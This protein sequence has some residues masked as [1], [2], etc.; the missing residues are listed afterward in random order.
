MGVQQFVSGVAKLAADLWGGS[1]PTVGSNI[2]RVSATQRQSDY[3]IALALYEGQH[4]YFLREDIDQQYSNHFTRK[5]RKSS[6]FYFN[7]LRK[8]IDARARVYKSM[9]KFTG[10]SPQV[11]ELLS[12]GSFWGEIIQADR[13]SELCDLCPVLIL[14]TR[15]NRLSFECVPPDQARIDWDPYVRN[16]VRRFVSVTEAA[17]SEEGKTSVYRDVWTSDSHRIY[18]DDTD[19]T[20]EVAEAQGLA[21]TGGVN[22]WG[23]VPI[24]V[25]RARVAG[26]NNPWGQMRQD[27]IRSQRQLNVKLTDLNYLIKLYYSQVVIEG[28]PKKLGDFQVGADRP[29]ILKQELEGKSPTAKYLT[30]EVEIGSVWDAIKQ[31]IQYIAFNEGLAALWDQ[32]G[33]ASTSGE[34]RKVANADMQ[35]IRESK[36]PAHLR[37]WQDVERVAHVVLGLG[38]PD[39]ADRIKIEFGDVGVYMD[40][41]EQRAAWLEEIKAGISTRAQWYMEAHPGTSEEEAQEKVR[42][43]LAAERELMG[44]VQ[45]PQ[46]P[47]EEEFMGLKALE[48]EGKTRPAQKSK[49][50]A[51]EEEE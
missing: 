18:R 46:V 31:I 14:P 19:V 15:D 33:T 9:P 16:R 44:A 7:V 49:P 5:Q 11:S 1:T 12:D 48:Q 6:M 24:V 3:S 40:E 41:A 8:I 50:P 32:G 26:S 22:P 45:A 35:E 42:E 21:A 23:Q 47:P 4:E 25:M 37:F 34:S 17:D 27:L 13:I 51:P 28:D 43:N 20:D 30:P 39:P 10:G 29:L 38:E 2:R 36:K